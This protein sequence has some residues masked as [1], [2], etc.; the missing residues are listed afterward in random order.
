M[1]VAELIEELQQLDKD[2]NIFIGDTAGGNM[3]IKHIKDNIGLS[4]TLSS[5]RPR[6]F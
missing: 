4:Y 3:H 5:K 2:K 1:T 6:L